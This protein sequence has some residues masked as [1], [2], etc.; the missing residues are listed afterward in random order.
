MGGTAWRQR[1]IKVDLTTA[2][3]CEICGKRD[4]NND[5]LLRT[6]CWLESIHGRACN[7]GIWSYTHMIQEVARNCRRLFEA[8]KLHK[9]SWNKSQSLHCHRSARYSTKGTSSIA[10]LWIH[11][12][13]YIKEIHPQTYT[14][15]QI[16]T[17]DVRGSFSYRLLETAPCC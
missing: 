5:I 16:Y 11:L 12:H 1:R 17:A 8:F 10:Y 7:P 2:M 15:I 14:V 6:K 13:F 3:T 9:S 4:H